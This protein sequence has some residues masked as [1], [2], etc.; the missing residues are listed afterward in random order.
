MKAI[1]LEDEQLAANRL[2]RMLKEVA[3]DIKVIATFESIADTKDYL[4]RNSNVDLLFFDIHVAD[5]NS[6]ELF[7]LANIEGKV[8]FT[9]AYDKYAIEAFRKNAIDYLLKPLKKDQLAQAIEK[10]TISAQENQSSHDSSYRK[11]IVVNFMSKIQSL[12]IADIA[13]IFSLNKI[14][15]FYMKNGDRHASDY[16]LQDLEKILNPNQFF[17]A[18][19]Q[20]I[21]NIDSLDQIR[22]HQASRLRITLIPHIDKEIVISTDKTPL[23][24]KWLEK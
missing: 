24:K 5:G 11:R 1:I 19:R 2:K 22:K 18:N 13:Y 10:A 21:I 15:Y 4:N 23:F 9:T 16:R 20:F 8:I 14:S 12:K 17:R 3:S 7:D 6:F